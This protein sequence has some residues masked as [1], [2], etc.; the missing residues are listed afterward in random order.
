MPDTEE[1]QAWVRLACIKAFLLLLLGW[2]I[3]PARTA[4]TLICLRCKIWTSWTIGHG[5]GWDLLS[6]ISRYLLPLTHLWPHVEFALYVISHQHRGHLVP[7]NQPWA[8]TKG[9]MRWFIRVSHPIVNPPCGHSWLRSWCPSS[10]CPS[11]RGGYCWAA[12]GQTSSRPIPDH[13]QHQG[14]SGRCNGTF[15]CVS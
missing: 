6:Y 12:M 2:T 1:E 4:K 13:Q 10:S 8:H 3:F 14:Q 5:V 11:L 7:D 15:C 9:Y